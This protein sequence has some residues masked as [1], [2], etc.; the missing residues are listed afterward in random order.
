M[1]A[2]VSATGEVAALAAG[3]TM[4]TAAIDGQTGG[5]AIE[6][7]YLPL[8][9]HQINV[10]W[11]SSVFLRGPDG[12]TMLLEAGNTGHGTSDVV[13]YLQSI[14]VPSQA[15]LS[16][17]IA[18]H[19]HCDHLGGLDEVINAGYNVRIRNYYNGSAETSSCV[20]QWHAAA[21]TTTAR[22]VTVPVPGAV[23]NLGNGA[24]L[25]F[26]AVNGRIIGGATV[27]VSD[28]N[29]RSIAVLIQYGGF[30]YLWGSDLGG[31]DADNACTG[32]STG[33]NNVETPLIQAISPGGAAPLLTGA[34]VDVLYVNHHGSESSTNSAFMNLARPQVATIGVGAGQ[35]S[36]FQLPRKSVIEGVLLAAAA[37]CV[38]ALPAVVLQTEEGA[39]IGIETSFAG[40]SVGDIKVST[41]GQG[42][43]AVSA[44]GRVTQGPNELFA[45]GLPRNF[46]IDRIPAAPMSALAAPGRTA[47][48]R[49]WIWSRN[50]G[51]QVPGMP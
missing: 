44:S 51:K 38:T 40:Y 12:S 24:K 25:T 18:G 41:T 49:R 16:Y 33:Q 23:V 48:D 32:R 50:F 35:S 11:G 34:G 27:A 9:L 29:D 10:G 28:E 5:T 19:Q 47:P 8:E 30:D 2:S 31:G 46:N 39:P 36:N 14:G 21:I 13:P 15:G 45:A 4:I 37:A 7:R 26:V 1:I 3:H 43:F 6:V 42:T 17:T 20:T 22:D